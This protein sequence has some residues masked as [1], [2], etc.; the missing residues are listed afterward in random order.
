MKREHRGDDGFT[1]IARGRYP[2]DSPVV[3]LV[4][5][6][7]EL[8]AVLGLV[9][10]V[11]ERDNVLR[12]LGLELR[13]HQQLLMRIAGY[14]ALGGEMSSVKPPI[15]D[16][17]VRSVEEEVE[18]IWS[19]LKPMRKFLVPKGPLEAALM[20]YART[21]CRRVERRA[22]KLFRDGYIAPPVYKYL[23]R[24]SDLLFVYTRYIHH[25]AGSGEEYLE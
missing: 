15:D 25:L 11:V 14:V 19:R 8:V 21:V 2:K 10:A 22:V 16:E 23:N 13:K 17:L 24:L 1:D 20:N 6:L 18:C 3:E 7:D 5:E 4:G 12:D 9:R